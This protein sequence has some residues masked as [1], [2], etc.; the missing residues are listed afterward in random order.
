MKNNKRVNDSAN[1]V[2]GPD[3]PFAVQEAYS[4]ASFNIKSTVVGISGCKIIAVVSANPMDGKSTTCINLAISTAKTNAKVL[5]ID[6]D[7]RRPS[8]HKYL[9]IENNIGLSNVLTGFTNLD[10]AIQNTSH[11]ISCLT[12]GQLPNSPIEL[13]MNGLMNELLELL[14]K[15]YDYIFIDTPPLPMISDALS[16]SEMVTGYIVT[17]RYE[18]TLIKMLDKAIDTLKLANARILGIV[19]ND[20]AYHSKSEYSKHYYSK[21]SGYYGYEYKSSKDEQ[22]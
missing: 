10:E 18:N 1:R 8:I 12:A 11:G 17:V 6:A 5:V 7:M 21:H 4:I 3:S 16:L 9:N 15:H 13:L 14:S 22:E 20:S 19:V 2:V